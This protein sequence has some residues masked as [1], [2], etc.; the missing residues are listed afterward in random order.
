MLDV[1]DRPL[2]RDDPDASVIVKQ[3]LAEDGVRF[4]LGVRLQQITGTPAG[5]TAVWM[6]GEERAS[7]DVDAVLVAAGRTPNV[8]G[9]D[10]DAAGVRSGPAGI[11]VNDHLQTTNRRVYAAGDVAAPWKFTHAA[12][13]TARLVLQNAFF[14]GRRRVED[15]VIPWCTYTSPEVAHVGMTHEQA[16]ST[17]AATITVPFGDVD[18][19]VLDRDIDGFVRLHHHAGRLRGGTIVGPHAGNLIGYVAQVLG[20]GV[21]STTWR[22]PSSRIHVRREPAQGGRCLPAHPAHAT[23]AARVQWYFEVMR[24]VSR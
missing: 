11:D 8:E 5:T 19:A 23:G 2:P 15:L 16:S 10:L 12:D 7:V 18:R 17:G 20:P 22:Q 1:V 13:A 3:E 24:R 6:R 14:F 21:R 4:G 9:L